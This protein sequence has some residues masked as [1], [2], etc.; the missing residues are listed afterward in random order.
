MR[1]G[2]NGSEGEGRKDSD[3]AKQRRETLGAQWMREQRK[4]RYGDSEAVKFF[5]EAVVD[6]G[7]LFDRRRRVHTT[8][9]TRRRQSGEH[10]V[11]AKQF[12]DWQLKR[13]LSGCF[14]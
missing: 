11:R 10:C 13:P 12:L 14:Q 9:R 7:D 1:K 4:R 5:E 6:V 3:E 2:R 8:L